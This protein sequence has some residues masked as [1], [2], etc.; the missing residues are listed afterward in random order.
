MQQ[1]GKGGNLSLSRKLLLVGIILALG[2]LLLLYALLYLAWS[3]LLYLLIWLAWAARGR[4]MLIVYSDSPIWKS[5]FEENILPPLEDVSIVL[6]WSQRKRWRPS[7]AALAFSHFAGEHDFNP[8]AFM[9]QP[10]HLARRFRF[11]EAFKDYKHGRT[12]PVERLTSELLEA[13]GRPPLQGSPPGRQ[14]RQA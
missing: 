11:Y 7:L 6:N 3:G 13:A 14:E 12:A 10:F 4:Q 8:A 5:Y 9:F 1:S 2:P